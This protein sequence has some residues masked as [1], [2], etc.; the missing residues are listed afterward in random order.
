MFFNG[1][2]SLFKANLQ[3]NYD[4][5]TWYTSSHQGIKIVIHA[6]YA[7]AAIRDLRSQ[8]KAGSNQDNWNIWKRCAHQSLLFTDRKELLE[9]NNDA[10]V[11]GGICG[12]LQEFRLFQ[13]HFILEPHALYIP[14]KSAL[15]H[16]CSNFS[17]PIL[18]H[19]HNQSDL[20]KVVD[21]ANQVSTGAVNAFR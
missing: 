14:D 3:R 9:I 6:W 4:P 2:T 17:L 12:S 19:L 5:K 8:L 18:G 15:V 16:L 7:E 10:R 13:Q 21:Y 1:N 20:L 11:A